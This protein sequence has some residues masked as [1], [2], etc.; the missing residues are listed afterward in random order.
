[1]A[2]CPT[3]HPNSLVPVHQW[4]SAHAKEARKNLT[5]C[6]SCHADGN[7]CMKC[8]SAVSG[9][10]V[11]PHPRSWSSIKGRLSRA[12]DNKSCLKCHL[13]VP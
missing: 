5:S 13:T 8:H 12:S 4:S 10:K 9:L 3:C 6:Q 11:N 2:Q 7:V 1:M